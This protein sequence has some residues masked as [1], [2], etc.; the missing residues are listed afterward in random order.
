[1]ALDY[2]KKKKKSTFCLENGL[3]IISQEKVVEISWGFI[4]LVEEQSII[5][6]L[7]LITPS[8]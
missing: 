5:L 4:I 3:S 1:M 7:L 6:D 8:E 2:W